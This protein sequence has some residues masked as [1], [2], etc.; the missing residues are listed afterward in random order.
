MIP[1]AV[2][3]EL[4]GLAAARHVLGLDFR[5]AFWPAG[6]AV[7]DGRT[8][9]PPLDGNVLARGTSFVYPP[10]VALLVAPLALLPVT[11][12]TA[13]AV[14][15]TALALAGTL[16]ALDVR[17]WR[18][19][20]AAFASA[21]VLDCIQTASMSAFFALGI[22]LAWRFRAHGLRTPLLVAAL[23]AAKLFLW[24]LLLWLVVVRGVRSAL[25]T[26]LGAGA[27]VLA[28]WLLGFPGL[29]E[30]PRLLSLLVDVEGR[31][32]YSPRALALALGAG[33]GLAQALAVAAGGCVLATAA[34]ELRSGGA[35]LRALAL[36]L[37]ASLLFSP[38]VWSH[39]FVV[40]LPVIAIASPRLRWPWFVLIVF[41][42]GGGA[43]TVAGGTPQVAL[44][45]A[46]MIV[47]ALA[48]VLPPRATGSLR[49][50]LRRGTFASPAGPG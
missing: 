21:P 38:L 2:A 10:L 22:A 34:L 15:A 47:A 14:I 37:L 1:A 45:L 17:D 20:G 46:V 30:Y 7:L 19:Y 29:T 5:E 49:L 41:W 25:L 50:Q 3:G 42:A 13:L 16:R 27:A 31:D 48:G 40:L 26:A 12:A 33:P 4:L 23:I 28:P 8:P 6:R 9:Y 24:P 35:Q 39:Y 43:P 11:V 44:G 18:C 36:T 32:G